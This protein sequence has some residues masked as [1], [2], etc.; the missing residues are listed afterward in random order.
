ME[1]IMPRWAHL[2]IDMQRMFDEE[3]AWNVPWMAKVSGQIE[4]LAARTPA[5]TIFTRFIPPRSA[6]QMPG[7]WKTYYEKWDQMTLNRL[8]RELVDLLP[9][10]ARFVPPARIFD[11]RTYSPWVD[12]RLYQFLVQDGV[13]TLIVTGGETDVCVLATVVGAID[14]GYRVLIPHDAVCSGADST[15]D[16]TLE[17]LGA[18]FSVQVE[19]TS[20]EELLAKVVR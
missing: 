8:P 5:R 15:H 6:S 7:A 18:R 1:A 10:L 19:M 17:L 20:T 11:K 2:C 12:G 16:S 9:A 13:D 14:L 4:E 3:T